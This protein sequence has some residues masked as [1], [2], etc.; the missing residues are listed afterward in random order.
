MLD[1]YFPLLL[2]SPS[3]HALLG[4]LSKT[5]ETHLS[6]LNSL[7]T[8]GGPLSAFAKLHEEQEIAERRAKAASKMNGLQNVAAGGVAASAGNVKVSGGGKGAA[9]ARAETGGGIGITL[10][11]AGA[12]KTRRTVAMEESMLVGAYSLERLEI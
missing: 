11:T 8:L 4:D 6:G 9:A 3:T 2:N 12:A 7:I 10:G 1:T 5:V